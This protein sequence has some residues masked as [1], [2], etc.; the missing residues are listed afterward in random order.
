MFLAIRD[1]RFAKGRFA[2]MG[3]VVALI[4]LLLVMLSGLTAGLGNQSTSAIA[5]LP[6]QQI[7]F[8]A[9]AGSQPT[10][11]YTESEVSR[12]QLQSWR[13]RPGVASV[14]ELG[15]SQTRFQ[16]VNGNGE[17]SGT[18]NVAVFGGDLVD[19]DDGT[20]V[21]SESVAKELD[22]QPGSRVRL[23]GTTFVVSDVVGD[24]WYS[25]TPVVWTTLSDWRSISHSA[26]DTATVLGVKSDAGTS[27]D[28]Q[29]AN[30][31]AGTVSSDVQGSFQALGSYKSE[32]G[33]LMLMQ[34]FLYGISAL[35]IM[36][37]LTVWTVQRTRDIAVLRALG[38]STGYV[39][40]D[41]LAQAA[42]VLC[43]GAG[44]GG[45]LGLIGGTAAAQAAP[46]LITPLTTLL[47]V[48]GIVVLG[49]AGAV[50][51]VGRVTKVDPLLA[52]GGN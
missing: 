45:L 3:G 4:T 51:A 31:A 41:A 32:N 18:A 13:G 24:Q 35:V 9:P 52:L 2:L 5:A 17:A 12:D 25:H 40:R 8:G 1:I 47:P 20:A 21:V 50:L 28:I 15:I 49:L 27:L 14:H 39:L 36:A 26:P 48:M 10:L 42:I 33:S 16:S 43:A 6:V 23:A 7:V 34:A 19:V 44:A 38:G 11:S 37:F 30:A 29:A 46:F 22:V